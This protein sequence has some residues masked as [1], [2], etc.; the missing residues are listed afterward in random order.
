MK[1][2]LLGALGVA[3][4]GVMGLGLTN[5]GA[6]FTDQE[7]TTVTAEAGQLEIDLG[8]DLSVPVTVSGLLPGVESDAYSL[9][10]VN[11]NGPAFTPPEEFATVKYRIT[12]AN[13]TSDQPAP[14]AL[15]DV[16]RVRLV[17]GNCV[18]PADDPDGI[19]PE[20][21][22]NTVLV[23]NLNFNSLTSAIGSGTLAQGNTHCFNMY[24]SLPGSAGNDYQNATGSFDIVVDATQPENPGWNE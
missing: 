20:T 7:S 2:K 18:G 5:T 24:F 22:D 15:L 6:W 14:G 1:F 11:P 13:E 23:K 21:Y 16:L 12:T 8:G 4:V 9:K 19:N 10:I 3:A 17:H